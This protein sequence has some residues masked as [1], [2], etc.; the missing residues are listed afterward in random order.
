MSLKNIV[1]PTQFTGLHAH[2]SFSTFDGLGYPKDH[3][4]F[5]TSEEQGGNSWALTDHGNGSGLAHA[6]Q[7]AM[8]LKKKGHDYRQIYGCEFYFVPS[9]H[10]WKMQYD[11]HRQKVKDERDNKKAG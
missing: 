10:T 2:T 9:L 11:E 3:I 6:N 8:S 1:P 4:N 5:I 7:H